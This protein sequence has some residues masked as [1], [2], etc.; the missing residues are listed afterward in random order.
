MLRTHRG[1]TRTGRA[2][3]MT[4]LEHQPCCAHQVLLRQQGR[5]EKGQPEAPEYQ[6]IPVSLSRRR[7]PAGPLGQGEKSRDIAQ[8]DEL[9][10]K[11]RLARECRRDAGLRKR[12]SESCLS[13]CKWV[14][15][16]RP[17]KVPYPV[18]GVGGRV[19]GHFRGDTAIPRT[20]V[21]AMVQAQIQ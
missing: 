19:L 15:R 14:T 12:T 10:A 1:E 17:T 18:R 3:S 2:K 6:P 9:Q 21:S 7:T 5:F 8:L 11:F 20:G 4:N 16:W 13:K